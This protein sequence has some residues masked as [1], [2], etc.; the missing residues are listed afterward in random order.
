MCQNDLRHVA[1]E[2]LEVLLAGHEIRLAI[3][4]NDGSALGVAAAFDDDHALGGHAAGLLIRF[5]K[6]CLAH[7]FCGRV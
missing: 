3:H 4:F 2:S 7:Q 1:C 5:R 6:T